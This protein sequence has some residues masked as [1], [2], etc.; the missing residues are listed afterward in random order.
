MDVSSP[1]NPRDLGVY[2]DAHRAVIGK[3]GDSFMLVQDQGWC[4][5]SLESYL[6]VSSD[7]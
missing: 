3:V 5:D 7:Q 1:R 6:L 2:D 4:S